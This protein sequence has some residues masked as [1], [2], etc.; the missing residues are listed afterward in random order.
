VGEID[1]INLILQGASTK[2]CYRPRISPEQSHVVA[3]SN[4]SLGHK[5]IFAQQTVTRRDSPRI[6]SFILV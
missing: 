3:M 1:L 6:R 4:A 2:S 5:L